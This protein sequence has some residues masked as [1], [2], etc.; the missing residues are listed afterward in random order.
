MH[1]V[2]LGLG[3]NIEPRKNLR[4]GIAELR[5]LFDN[6]TLS[7]VYRSPAVGFDGEPFLN[8]VVGLET[9]VLL[10]ELV[11]RLR[12]LEYAYGRTINSTKFSSRRLDIDILTFDAYWGTFD[13]VVLP[14]PEVVV[15][16]YVLC[17][18]AELAPNLVL[19]GLSASLRELWRGYDNP[20]QPVT[21]LGDANSYLG[22][23]LSAASTACLPPGF[24]I[25]GDDSRMDL[26]PLS[27]KASPSP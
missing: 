1:Q 27:A 24:A 5:R 10:G 8:L 3:S 22:V 12:A 19:P 13:G 17:P 23:C 25:S 16:A 7:S 2:H 26:N 15:N 20:R 6:V 9:D 14:R 21:N 11:V 18:F 4:A